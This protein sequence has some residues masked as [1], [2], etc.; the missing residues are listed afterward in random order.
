MTQQAHDVRMTSDQRRCKVMTLHR[1]CYDV[2]LTSCARWGQTDFPI[3]VIWASPLSFLGE[4][5]IVFE[6]VLTVLMN[7]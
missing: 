1:R 6:F 4:S 2:I 3:V 7:F 5:G